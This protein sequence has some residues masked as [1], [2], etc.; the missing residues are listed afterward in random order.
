MGGTGRYEDLLAGTQF[1]RYRPLV[2]EKSSE[3]IDLTGSDLPDLQRRESS[4]C[5]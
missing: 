5:L 3:K 4:G 1:L 2:Q